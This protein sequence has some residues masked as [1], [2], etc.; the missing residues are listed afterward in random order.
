M[1]L[2]EKISGIYKIHN[3]VNNKMYI[4]SSIEIYGR[5]QDHKKEL[6]HNYHT[7]KR[8]QHS[9]NKYGEDKFVFEILENVGNKENL[10][11]R[12]QYWMNYY[13]SYNR[14]IGF[15]INPIASSQL[16]FK[17]SDESKRKMSESRK[18][19]KHHL[20]GKFHSDESKQ[21]MSKSHTGKKHNDETKQKMSND[22]MKHVSS[23]KGRK[24]TKEH[25]QKRIESIKNKK[26]KENNN[27][28][29]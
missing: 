9:W 7:N 28:H 6:R 27:E 13:D 11:D 12:E 21:K 25:I 3:I 14:D 2:I 4:G 8:L 10:L 1:I 24:Q 19:E 20:Y 23:L 29:I 18:G 17:H 22:R 16:G 5:W 15:N 26:Y